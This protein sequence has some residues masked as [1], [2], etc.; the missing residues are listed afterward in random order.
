[1]TLFSRTLCTIVLAAAASAPVLA[2][3]DAKFIYLTRHAEKSAT[4]TDPVLTAEGKIRAQNIAA[5]LKK[6]GITSI[7]STDY[8]RTRETAQPLSALL[9]IPV[10]TY[11]GA[12][13]ATFAET[14]K[15]LPGNTLVVGHSDTTPEL[16]RQLGGTTGLSIAENEFDKLF[17]VAIGADGDVT[18]TLLHSLPSGSAPPCAAV[19]LNKTGLSAAKDSWT[20]FTIT[21]PECANTLTV[22][23]AGTVGDG[24]LYVRLGAQPTTTSYNCRPYKPGSTESCT[25][26]DPAAGVWYIGIRAYSAFSGVTLDAAAKP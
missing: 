2:L 1:M 19:T 11:D 5:T 25:M 23:L 15:A 18:T 13:L 7:Y 9:S 8:A 10:Q 26:T 24:D 3:A 22:N 21:V 6:A 16:I 20:Y 4:G 14:L 12:Q 17:Q